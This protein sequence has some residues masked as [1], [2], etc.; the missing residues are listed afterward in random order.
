MSIKFLL[1][2]V[3]ELS[4]SWTNKIM[5][6]LFYYAVNIIKRL[7]VFYHNDFW[8]FFFWYS[9]LNV[10]YVFE[11]LKCT[12][13][14]SF[15]LAHA[16]VPLRQYIKNLISCISNNQQKKYKEIFLIGFTGWFNRGVVY[17]Q[18]KWCSKT[19]PQIIDF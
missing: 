11:L 12:K 1:L 9:A 15:R 13:E 14:I 18:M 19:R 5:I 4:A 16:V 2:F 3:K 17:R 10:L 6:N 7:I 8:S